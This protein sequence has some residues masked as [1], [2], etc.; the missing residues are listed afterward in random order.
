MKTASVTSSLELASSST[1]ETLQQVEASVGAVSS[2]IS[3]LEEKEEE[4]KEDVR[5]GSPFLPQGEP[6]TGV[7][8]VAAGKEGKVN[9]KTAYNL[10]L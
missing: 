2:K 8:D 4:E 1:T 10:H 6:G 3:L 5:S 9:G 7:L